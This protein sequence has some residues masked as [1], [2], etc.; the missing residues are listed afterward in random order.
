MLDVML[1]KTT[2]RPEVAVADTTDVPPTDNVLG[3][4]LIA[5]IVWVR[6]PL[7]GCMTCMDCVTCAAAL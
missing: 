4:K 1:L 5:P 6:P 2:G 7:C 3:E